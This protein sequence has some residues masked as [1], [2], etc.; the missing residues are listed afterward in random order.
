MLCLMINRKRWHR[1]RHRHT[2]LPNRALPEVHRNR[3]ETI[4]THTYTISFLEVAIPTTNVASITAVHNASFRVTTTYTAV[5]FFALN[6]F[7][8][9]YAR[10]NY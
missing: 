9:V 10:K 6:P 2:L 1:H 3:S 7:D 4:H 8:H 5:I